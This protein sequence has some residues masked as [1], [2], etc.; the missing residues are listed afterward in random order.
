VVGIPHPTYG[1]QI[2]AVVEPADEATAAAET[3]LI[4]HVKERLA[5]YKAPRHVR[6]VPTIGRA[7]NGKV[8]YKRHRSESMEDLGAAS[9]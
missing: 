7:P 4:A 6:T 5:S 2:V 9:G 3:D 8:D 1:E